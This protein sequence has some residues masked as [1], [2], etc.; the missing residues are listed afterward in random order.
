MKLHEIKGNSQIFI[1]KE[2]ELTYKPYTTK[3]TKSYF[4][5]QFQPIDLG[6]DFDFSTIK[7]HTGTEIVSKNLQNDLYLN[8]KE[9]G[10]EAIV[11]QDDMNFYC[12]ITD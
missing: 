4:A 10:F 7:V 1:K 6:E 11:F 5:E 12:N 9:E 3:E 2:G 8:I